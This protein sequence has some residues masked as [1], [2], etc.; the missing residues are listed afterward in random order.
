MKFVPVLR[1]LHRS[2]APQ[3]G[4]RQRGVVAV[5]IA[6]QSLPLVKG[7]VE[8]VGSQSVADGPVKPATMPFAGQRSPATLPDPSHSAEICAWRG[9]VTRWSLTMPVACM[10]A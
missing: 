1:G 7:A 3:G 5:T 2:S 8:V 4:L 6:H 10:K 9:Q